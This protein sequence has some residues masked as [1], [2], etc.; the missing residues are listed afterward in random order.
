M[1]PEENY[2]SDYEAILTH[3]Y[4]L[5]AD[6]WTTPDNRLVKGSPFSMIECVQYLMELGVDATDSILMEC[7]RILFRVWREDGRFQVYPKGVIYPC[8]TI[9]VVSTL[10][11]MG[12]VN[13]PRIQ[14]S[15]EYLVETQYS[16]G[17]WR[18]NKFSYGHG[19]ETEYSNPFPT[20]IALNAFRF[21]QY[22]DQEPLLDKSVDF[23]LEH[24]TIR[25]PI[26]PCHYGIGSLFLQV[27]FPFR[28]YNLFFYVY[29]LSFYSRA[30]KDARFREAFLTLQSKT[31]DGKI[32]VERVSPKLKEL[33]FCKKNETSELATMRYLEIL[34]NI[35][36][37]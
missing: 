18:C 10:C 1:V 30:R 35:E 31:R 2:L 23:L 3:R 34:K 6:Y 9:H 26:G 32:V 4:D 36:K 5:G 21:S 27:E 24:W 29:V 19:P 33:S 16:D 37:N 20:L 12:F 22:L 28:N 8:Q 11:S 17:G 14:K 7:A 25:R 13:D 15:L